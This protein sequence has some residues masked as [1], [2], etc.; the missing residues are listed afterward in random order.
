MNINEYANVLWSH[1]YIFTLMSTYQ[2]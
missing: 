1:D 2:L